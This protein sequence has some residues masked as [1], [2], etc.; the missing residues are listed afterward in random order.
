MK[1]RVAQHSFHLTPQIVVVAFICFVCLFSLNAI[2]VLTPLQAS[3][4]WTAQPMTQVTT[5]F[6]F[7]AQ[8]TLDTLVQFPQLSADITILQKE[9]TL[10][11]AQQATTLSLLQENE[12]LRALLQVDDTGAAHQVVGRVAQV[13]NYVTPMISFKPEEGAPTSGDLV[14]SRGVLL[15]FLDVVEHSQATVLL[16]ERRTAPVVARTTTGVI[17]VVHR[18]GDVFL[19]TDVPRDTAVTPGEL[20]VTAGQPG[21]PADILIGSVG[22]RVGTRT[23]SVQSFRVVRPE[24]FS[25]VSLV[26]LRSP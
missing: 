18:E 17:G 14:L 21:V 6:L 16:L 24:T 19:F 13:H 1:R 10:L 8:H 25:S 2:G 7:T 23:S 12:A 11:K 3:I 22:T 4:R 9:N 20:L 26:E 5:S 15:G